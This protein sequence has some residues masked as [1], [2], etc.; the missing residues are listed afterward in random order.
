MTRKS[1]SGLTKEAQALG[2]Q[3]ADLDE[4]ELVRTN[5]LP[6]LQLDF[7]LQ[8][9]SSPKASEP[10][11]R[12]GVPPSTDDLQRLSKQLLTERQKGGAA[13]TPRRGSGDTNA[14]SSVWSRLFR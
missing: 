1:P 7:Q 3:P 14:P 11:K 13:G 9:R 12:A 8:R 4:L 2:P 6:T 10:T 5:R